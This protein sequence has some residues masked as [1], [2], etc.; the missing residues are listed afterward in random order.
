L[1]PAEPAPGTVPIS[2]QVSDDFKSTESLTGEI[3]HLGGQSA[4]VSMAK[5]A[6]IAAISWFDCC[7]HLV[8]HSIEITPKLFERARSSCSS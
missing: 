7:A 1:A 3:D 4:R 2:T 5:R 6:Q 8:R